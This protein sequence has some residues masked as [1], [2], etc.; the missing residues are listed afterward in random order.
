M[1]IHTYMCVYI[2]IS[3]D[4]FAL[5][6]QST[7]THTSTYASFRQMQLFVRPPRR[8]GLKIIFCEYNNM[9]QQKQ[10]YDV[11][12]ENKIYADI[13][14]RRLETTLNSACRLSS[15]CSAMVR[16]S[17]AAKMSW[18]FKYTHTRTYTHLCVCVCALEHYRSYGSW[19][20]PG[21]ACPIEKTSPKYYFRICTFIKH[22]II[23]MQLF[24]FFSKLYTKNEMLALHLT[25]D[26]WYIYID[27]FIYMCI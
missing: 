1:A 7:H 21:M 20:L 27:I 3:G 9:Q 17:A 26:I 11:C 4:I 14:R 10:H 6:F 22:L 24:F 25:I 16:P 13:G 15:N 5:L 19:W 2:H 12:L 8:R 23:K 18:N